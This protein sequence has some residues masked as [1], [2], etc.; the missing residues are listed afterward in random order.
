MSL[1]V[2]G[3]NGDARAQE[4]LCDQIQMPV[5]IDVCKENTTRTVPD[6]DRRGGPGHEKWFL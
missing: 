2:A 3:Q 5:A 1:A 4:M 6:C